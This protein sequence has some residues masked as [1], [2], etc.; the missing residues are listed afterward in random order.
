MI[1]AKSRLFQMQFKGVPRYAFGLVEVDFSEAPERPDAVDVRG[2]LHKLAL[3]MADAKMVVEAP[4]HQAVIVA[5]ALGLDHGQNVDI[6]VF[7]T[8]KCIFRAIQD[9]LGVALPATFERAKDDGFAACAPDAFTVRTRRTKVA[10]VEFNGHSRFGRRG[11][12]RQ[13]SIAQTQVERIDGAGAQARDSGRVRGR[14]IQGKKPQQVA[15]YAN[16]NFAAF[17]I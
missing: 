12:P 6:T 3:A 16:Q 11:V 10:S 13:E 14:Q 15:K 17:I 4:V 5:P 1:E 7:N 8:L 9:D 2:H